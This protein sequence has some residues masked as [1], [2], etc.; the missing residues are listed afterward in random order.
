V[1]E[2]F[3]RSRP[4]RF[5]GIGAAAPWD[6]PNRW[7]QT[8]REQ[9]AMP[10]PVIRPFGYRP[11]VAARDVIELMKR[12]QPEQPHRYVAMTAHNSA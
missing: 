6:P 10:P 5:A 12:Q 9:P 4:C 11:A 3:G 2:A 1:P 7:K 8:P